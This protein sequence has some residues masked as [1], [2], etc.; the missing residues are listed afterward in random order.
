MTDA[1]Q[2]QNPTPILIALAAATL[3]ASLGIS[4]AAVLLPTLAHSFSATVSEV[5]W[6]MLAY[7]TSVTI[8]V[9]SAGRLGDLFGHRRLLVFGLIVFIASSVLS[10]TA[11]SLSLLIAG[12]ALQGLGGAILI[13]LPMSIA[14][15][16]VPT[17]RLGTAMGLLGTTSAAGTALGP[18]LGGVLLAMGNWRMAFWFLAGF[19]SVTLCL[20][21]ASITR[22]CERRTV[23]FRELDFPGTFV[24]VIALS[25]YAVATSGGASS[26]PLSPGALIFTVLIAIVVFG[27][28]EARVAS[29]LV[30][31][32][33]LCDQRTSIGLLMNL[34]VSAIMMSTL[35]VGPF[36][37]AFSLGLND[38]AIGL[39][40]AAGPLVAALFG[41]PAGWVTDRVGADRAMIIGLV[42]TTFGLL[43]L[44][45]LPR[46]F[47]VGGYLISLIMLTPGFQLFLAANNTAVL[48]HAARE[49]RGRLSGLLGLSRN[50]G[51]MTGA[52][53]ISTLFVAIVGTGDTANAPVADI[54]HAFS[55]TFTATACLA[56]IAMGLA[57]FGQV[58]HA[59][60]APNPA[61]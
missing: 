34:L 59:R 4:I 43:C 6:V 56:L 20:S 26:I 21:V 8:A 24:L 39:V 47:G 32:K 30:P 42:Q 5:Q 61:E 52:S 46:Y 18:S 60:E 44:A 1:I 12:R 17:E 14:R 54:A 9:V 40:L 25:A 19:A 3:T 36:Y 27:M 2:A 10:A 23:S 45:Y 33:L 41:V 38:A 31:M 15:D 55:M 28:V 22:D 48:I 57:I 16:L 11:P 35:V 50:L 49:Q 53:A 13:A 29:P 51:L 58:R 37:L 7:L